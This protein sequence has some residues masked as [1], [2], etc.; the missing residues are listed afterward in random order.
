MPIT[1]EQMA[2]DALAILSAERLTA[3]GE[4]VP[5]V[6]VHHSPHQHVEAGDGRSHLPAVR[7]PQP[8]GTFHLAEAEGDRPC[9][10]T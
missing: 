7:R 3:H 10:M 9:G 5:A 6:T 1:V 4:D 8:P 2:E